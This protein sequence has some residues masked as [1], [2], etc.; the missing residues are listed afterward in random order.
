MAKRPRRQN[1]G[2]RLTN[3]GASAVQVQI[4]YGLAPFDRIARQMEDKWGIDRLPELV[5]VETADK[6]GRTIGRL[7]AAIEAD[8]PDE[9]KR[10]AASA[11]RGLHAMDA[12]AT[13]AGHTTEAAFWEIE[14]DGFRFVILEDERQWPEFQRQ[15][16]ERVYFTKADVALALKAYSENPMLAAIKGAFPEAEIKSIDPIGTHTPPG[17]WKN[18]GDKIEL[19]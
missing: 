19:L 17:F 12:E 3:P 18:G 7:N 8:D 14:H 6:Y 10:I 16:K 13:A 2:D 9:V 1:K 4:D 15:N 11:I 5:S